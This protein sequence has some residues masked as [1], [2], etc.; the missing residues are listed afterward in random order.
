MR[1]TRT[2][3]IGVCTAVILLPGSL[4]FGCGG[5]EKP[6]AR[7]TF[8]AGW[9]SEETPHFRIYEPPD[10]PRTGYLKDFAVSCEITY[11]QLARL[12]HID[13][14][15]KIYIYR[16]ITSQDCMDAT[17]H[18]AGHVDGRTIYTRIGAPLGGAIAIAAFSNVVPNAHPAHIVSD[19][20]RKAIDSHA[21]NIHQDMALLRSQG[22]WTPLE[23]L[24][25]PKTPDPE[26]YEAASASFVAYL[27]QRH[28]I[29]QFK[30]IWKGGVDP[31][32]TLE[33]TLGVPLD[34]IEEDWI[35]HLEREAKRS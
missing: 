13:T 20:L 31:V 25:G 23:E 19:G 3:R 33:S 6:A 21:P 7:A 30:R 16:F 17:G 11:E 29:D 5:A 27:I 34:Q 15:E 8:A 14:N 35:V 32:V 24:L 2:C 26:T 10:S 1:L 12:L 9:N 28:G 4:L 18:L 22:R